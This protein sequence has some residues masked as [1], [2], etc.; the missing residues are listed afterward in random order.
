MLL[1]IFTFHLL[2]IIEKY[3]TETVSQNYEADI[4]AIFVS[5]SE[6]QLNVQSLQA[7]VTLAVDD[8]NKLY[9]NIKF[10][11][12]L[13]NDSKTCFN[14]N[15]G[16]LAAEEYYLSR[17]TAFIGPACSRAL[18]P[19]GRMASHWNVPIYT[20]GGIDTLFSAKN[21][22]NTLTRISFSIDQVTK[23][24]LNW[25]HI[26]IF[27]DESESSETILRRSFSETVRD[28]NYQIYPI[29]KEFLSSS[30]PNYKRMLLDAS[31][32]AR[33]ITEDI[34]IN[35]NGDREADY[36]LNDMDPDTANCN[37]F[38][39]R[40]L[41]DK[42]ENREINWAGNIGPP[43]DVPHCGFTGN[44]PECLPTGAATTLNIILPIL[45]AV[46]MF[47]TVIGIF[48]YRKIAL[49]A[50]LAD[51]WW[52]I[53]WSDLEFIDESHLGSSASFSRSHNRST[54]TTVKV[55]TTVSLRKLHDSDL[56][57]AYN[58]INNSLFLS[59]DYS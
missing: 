27:V 10:N 53:E 13:K 29:Y 1:I 56:I 23:F 4:V 57:V 7:A 45:F 33:A 55:Q 49:E 19:V 59:N 12:K 50:K 14:N 26:A 41:Y 37:F 36:T 22:F 6:L 34:R 3:S 25:Q 18:D 42:S 43:L 31:K 2:L 40:Q 38:G 58:V 15:A 9:P 24:L 5:E 46:I 16:V 11:L 51:H 48:A 44:A 20:A 39:S 17:V 30:L 32:G 47:I 35:E 54:P 21:I 8:V 28:S 52:K